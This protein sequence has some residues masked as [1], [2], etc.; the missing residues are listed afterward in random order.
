MSFS[1]SLEVSGIE[2]MHR[3]AA[4]RN[5]IAKSYMKNCNSVWIAAPITRA[6]D[7]KVAKELLGDA[8]GCS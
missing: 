1:F 8:F 3:S 7:D 5:G 6:V 2:I 4:A